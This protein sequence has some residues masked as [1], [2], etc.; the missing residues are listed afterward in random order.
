MSEDCFPHPESCPC[1][2]CKIREENSGVWSA[3]G[4]SLDQTDN[5][6]KELAEAKAE[7]A[8]LKAL[9]REVVEALTHCKRTL[10]ITDLTLQL[11]GS[12]DHPVGLRVVDSLTL[13]NN[14]LNRIDAKRIMEGE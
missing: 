2:A 11:R 1:E 10:E 6:L 7:L 4:A 8:S 14:I 9:V 12:I 13:V 3:L 5:V